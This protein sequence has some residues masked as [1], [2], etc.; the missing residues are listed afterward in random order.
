MFKNPRVLLGLARYQAKA[1]L[2][3]TKVPYGFDP[4]VDPPGTD[5][6]PVGAH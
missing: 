1:A 4:S 2:R 6:T 5:Y 3:R